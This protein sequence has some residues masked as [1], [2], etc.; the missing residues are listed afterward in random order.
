MNILHFLKP[1]NWSRLADNTTELNDNLRRDILFSQILIV[2]ITISAL[3]LFNDLLGANIQAIIIDTVFVVLLV[4]FYFLNERG[5]HKL[6]KILELSTLSFLI[7][8]LAAV[9]DERNRMAYNFFPLAILA[10]LIFYKT[11]LV[12]SII[13]SFISLSLLLLLEFT[14]FHPFGNISIK[15]GVDVVTTFINIVGSFVLLVMGL[16]F[17]V[18]LNVQ[19]EDELKIKESNLIKTNAEL[20]RFVYSAS[21]DLRA[22]LLSI[23]GL[24]NLMKFETT[25]ENLKEYIGKIDLRITDLDKFIGEIIDYSRNSRLELDLGVVSLDSL[26]DGCYGKL[27]YIDGAA[28]IALNKD[29][30]VDEIKTDA[31]R[32]GVVVANL[33]SN[34]I[35]YSDKTREQRWIRV[36]S[37]SQNGSLLI[38]VE[39]NGIGIEDIHHN[40]LF[41][42]F[43]RASEISEGSGLGLYIVQETVRKLAGEISVV[44]VPGQG[45]AFTLKLPM[46]Y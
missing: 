7:F 25:S 31:I 15:D 44:S 30:K 40:Q 26:I 12:F 37:R 5:H 16:V 22:P 35:K 13:F 6:A 28:T 36:A 21:H 20:D 8:V 4:F 32:L 45:S 33:L 10:F 3:H 24:T 17:L 34:A 41:N 9:L 2:G 23:R 38:T 27:K 29:L 39:D 19:A 11:E 42:M 18:K 46:Q 14:T 1:S 43:Y